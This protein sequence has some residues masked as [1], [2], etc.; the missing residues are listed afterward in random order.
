MTP[1]TRKA[2]R[3]QMVRMYVIAALSAEEAFW[4][5]VERVRAGESAM[6][7]ARTYGRAE[8]AR[9]IAPL[10]DAFAAA[11]PAGSERERAAAVQRAGATAWE[12]PDDEARPRGTY[13]YRSD[14]QKVVM[15]GAQSIARLGAG[16]CLACG[17][18]LT[19]DA[20]NARRRTCRAHTADA[21]NARREEALRKVFAELMAATAAGPAISPA[22]RPR[23]PEEVAQLDLPDG[24]PLECPTCGRRY[25]SKAEKVRRCAYGDHT[26][27]VLRPSHD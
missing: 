20:R 27:A 3:P 12:T 2:E 4:A 24:S 11:G 19:T 8:R 9:A 1:A 13:A 26:P 17:A 10:L 22:T 18:R 7:V 23:S 25:V 21:G 6:A 15:S 16:R 5:H 14:F